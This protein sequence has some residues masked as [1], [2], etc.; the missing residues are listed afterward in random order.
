MREDFVLLV[1]LET[2]AFVEVLESSVLRV[3]CLVVTDQLGLLIQIVQRFLLV[4]REVTRDREVFL[5]A[6]LRLLR[7]LALLTIHSYFVLGVG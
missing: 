5:L 7:R 4:I 1:D 6:P 3:T 2:D